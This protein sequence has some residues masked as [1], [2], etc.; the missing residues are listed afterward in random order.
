MNRPQPS[1]ERHE[2]FC[3]RE[4]WDRVRD[5]RGRTGTHH[6]TYELTLFDGRILRTRISHPVDRTVYGAGIWGHILRDQ[7]VVSEDEFWDCVLDGR[8]PNRGAPEV[9]KETLPADLVYMLIHRVGLAEE[10][11]AAMTKEDA[12]ARLHQYWIEGT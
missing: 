6:V 8:L 7:L 9:P 5:A 1:R 2:A 3:T 11:V 4:A 12:L 10:T